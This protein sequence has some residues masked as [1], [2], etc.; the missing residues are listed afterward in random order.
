MRLENIIFNTY[1][2]KIATNELLSLFENIP[3]YLHVIN[4]IV[5]SI[6]KSANCAMCA[7]EYV[8]E[9]MFKYI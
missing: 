8:G 3:Q 9:V 4:Y 2:I 5:T 6:S 7:C 1:S